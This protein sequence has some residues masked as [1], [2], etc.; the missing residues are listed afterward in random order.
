[1][2][3]DISSD[4]VRFVVKTDVYPAA[5]HGDFVGGGANTPKTAP[6]QKPDNIHT[7]LNHSPGPR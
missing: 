4:T 3:A 2:L 1:M 5:T 7:I 6:L